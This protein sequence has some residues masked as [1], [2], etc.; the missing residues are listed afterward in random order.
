MRNQQLQ[1]NMGK[2]VVMSLTWS[3]GTWDSLPTTLDKAHCYY[4]LS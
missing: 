3:I 1:T 2:K 4:W